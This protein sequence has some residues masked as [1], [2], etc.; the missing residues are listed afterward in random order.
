MRLSYP[1][2]KTNMHLMSKARVSIHAWSAPLL[3]CVS[4]SVFGETTMQQHSEM[5]ESAMS[6][7]HGMHRPSHHTPIGIIGGNYHKK[8]EFIFS[9]QLLKTD[10]Q[11]NNDSGKRLSDEQII[12]LPHPDGME[13][14][15]TNLSVV[16]ESMDMNMAMIEG[17]YGVS[18]RFT[19]M[20]MAM[21]SSKD[22]NL[23]TYSSMGDRPLLGAF[24]S[25]TSGLSSL[26]LSSLIR[27]KETEDY[28]FHAE[29]GF[30]KSVGDNDK[31]GEVLSPMNMRMDTRLPYAMQ[32]GDKSTSFIS[33]ITFVKRSNNWV[34]GSQLRLK[35]SINTEEWNFGNSRSL[36]MWFSR[37]FSD[38]LS[39]SVRGSVFSQ[40][41]VKGRD[42]MIMSPVQTSNPDNY[43]GEVFEIGLGLN[44][45]MGIGQ[46]N[47]L[48]FELAVPLKQNLNG[49]QM[50]RSYSFNAA[51]RKMF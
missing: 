46:G 34:Y 6:M 25:G 27:I 45:V 40:N 38:Q 51:F 28:S 36:N 16:P 33:A 21:Y 39:W 12:S 8:G 26:S 13:T 9:I 4:E 32:T 14:T 31:D 15:A 20:V 17:M 24:S 10:M 42:P 50:E 3:L 44:K 43:G 29:I 11:D 7:P 19:L 48:S 41:P 30:E 1:K 5:E 35:N 22:M 18:D 47:N 49:P 23:H 2:R 37:D